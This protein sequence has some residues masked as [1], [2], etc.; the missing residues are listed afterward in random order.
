MIADHNAER[1]ESVNVDALPPGCSILKGEK[2]QISTCL[3]SCK[4]KENQMQVDSLQFPVMLSDC[5]H[6]C[7][8]EGRF[9]SFWSG[10][11]VLFTNLSQFMHRHKMYFHISVSEDFFSS[12]IMLVWNAL[13]SSS[14][15]WT[16]DARSGNSMDWDM[17][18]SML[19]LNCSSA[20]PVAKR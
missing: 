4:Y 2:N 18:R 9:M 11:E 13:Q 8:E 6:V 5:C 15:K 20:D 7:H 19:G 3:T 12:C 17:W 14:L 1:Q 10:K 16:K